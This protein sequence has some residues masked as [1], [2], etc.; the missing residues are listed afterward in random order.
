MRKASLFFN[1]QKTRKEDI[2][3]ARDYFNLVNEKTARFVSTAE[4]AEFE[5]KAPRLGRRLTRGAGRG[6]MRGIRGTASAV[7]DSDLGRYRC[8]PGT[9]YG[10]TFT[11]RLGTN[12]GYSLPANVVNQ[13]GKASEA[14]KSIVRGYSCIKR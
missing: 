14:A 8:P 2:R 12:C 7:F 6:A 3:L 4:N 5:V 10:G 13:L 9:R 1:S 11:D